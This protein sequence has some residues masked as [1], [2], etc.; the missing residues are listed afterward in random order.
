[1]PG[2]VEVDGVYAQSRIPEHALARSTA[3]NRG[4]GLPLR[5]PFAL[6]MPADVSA[7]S[8]S[9]NPLCAAIAVGVV[10]NPT[11]AALRP[12]AC[13]AH[14][15]PRPSE[16]ATHIGC[17]PHGHVLIGQCPVRN[18]PSNPSLTFS[19]PQLLNSSAPQLHH[20]AQTGFARPSVVS[21][22]PPHWLPDQSAP[23]LSV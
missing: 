17:R 9:S 2:K 3:A 1:M 14:E 8:A 10:S 20:D 19:T 12:T 6:K 7:V 4:T 18:R 22:E 11:R 15:L 23:F 5:G 21:C 13:T 16:C